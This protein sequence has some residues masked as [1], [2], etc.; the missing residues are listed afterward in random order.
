[1][2]VGRSV[3]VVVMP[4][5]GGILLVVASTKNPMLAAGLLAVAAAIADLVTSACWTM[6]HD[7]AGD[8]AGT[9]TGCMNTFGNLGGAISPLV[10]GYAVQ[11][12]GSWSTPL[13]VTAG[14]CMLCGLLTLM[15]DPTRRLR[16]SDDTSSRAATSIQ[17]HSQSLSSESHL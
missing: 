10:V 13:V 2:K 5:S 14:V 12:W 6:C 1:L 3:G 16:T 15:I 17:S 7:V 8:A 11:W 4:V 9:A